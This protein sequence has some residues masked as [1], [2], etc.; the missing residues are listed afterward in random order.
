MEETAH[1]FIISTINWTVYAFPSF[2]YA[3]QIVREKLVKFFARS[4]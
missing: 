4:S 3:I 2:L 1:F